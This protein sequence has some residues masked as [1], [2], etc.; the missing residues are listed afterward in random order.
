[1]DTRA[2][3]ALATVLKNGEDEVRGYAAWALGSIGGEKIVSILKAA[4]LKEQNEQVLEEIAA[5]RSMVL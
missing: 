4:A 2:I 5:A 3:E 1:R